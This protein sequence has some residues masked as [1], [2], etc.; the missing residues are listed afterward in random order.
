MKEKPIATHTDNT[1]ATT[2]DNTMATNTD[3]YT[4]D[5]SNG[6]YA[7]NSLYSSANVVWGNNDSYY[8]E[9][10]Y[11]LYFDMK[12]E[13]SEVGALRKKLNSKDP[14]IVELAKSVIDRYDGL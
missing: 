8:K 12:I 9:K 1:M 2:T 6:T 11:E 7:D 10:L 3:T 13:R 5:T 4:L 14:E